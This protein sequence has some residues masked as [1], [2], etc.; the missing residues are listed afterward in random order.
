MCTATA[1]VELY[2]L[3]HVPY[4]PPTDERYEIAQCNQCKE[5]YNRI[6]EKIPAV[7]FELTKKMVLH[8]L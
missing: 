3:C 5:W 8:C 1:N 2:C 4:V 7:A 6:C